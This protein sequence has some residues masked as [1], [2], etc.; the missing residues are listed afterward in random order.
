[1][2]EKDDGKVR[3]APAV[4]PQ[5]TEAERAQGGAYPTETDSQRASEV[6]GGSIRSTYEP[7]GSEGSSLPDP[8]RPSDAQTAREILTD[9]ITGAPV[10]P[11]DPENN[12]A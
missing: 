12:Q 5:N 3:G 7:K 10:A 4:K 8:N 11:P 9:P 2:D 1:M 6:D